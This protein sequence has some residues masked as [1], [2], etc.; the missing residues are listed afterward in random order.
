[1]LLNNLPFGSHHPGGANFAMAD[2]SVRI[3]PDTIDFT[4]LGDLATIA[5]G[6]VTQAP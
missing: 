2:G 6:E 4:V 3:V 5:G 1:M